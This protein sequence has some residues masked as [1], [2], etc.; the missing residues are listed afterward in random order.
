MN[1]FA[2]GIPIESH[3]SI[4]PETAI[5]VYRDNCANVV[6]ILTQD[7]KALEQYLVAGE[8]GTWKVKR[9]N[10]EYLR[11]GPNTRL[12]MIEDV[13]TTPTARTFTAPRG[14]L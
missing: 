1:I 6:K 9:L 14:A 7:A 10:E 13:W 8:S 2:P 12:R 11:F 5:L 3:A 4:E